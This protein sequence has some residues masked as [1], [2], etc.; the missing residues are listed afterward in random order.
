MDSQGRARPDNTG[1]AE[2]YSLRAQVR[3]RYASIWAIPLV[4][5]AEDLV[6]GGAE[7]AVRVLDVGAGDRQ[8]AERLRKGCPGLVYRSVDPDDSH[9]HDFRSLSEVRE[10]FDR[11]VLF[12]VIEHLPRPEGAEMLRQARSALCSGGW[13]LVSTPNVH[14]PSQY[15][16]DV[17][18]VTPYSYEELGAAILRAGLQLDAIYRVHPGPVIEKLAKRWLCGWL[19]R[20]LG[21]DYAPGIVAVAHRETGVQRS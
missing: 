6:L 15:F 18:H 7:G 4:D 5:R 11:V 20:F 16:R 13:L 9:P 8:L 3:K 2:A 1:W 17:S 12:E 14:H 19:F 10:E 21:V